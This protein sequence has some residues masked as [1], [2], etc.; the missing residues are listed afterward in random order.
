MCGPT[1]GRAESRL[2]PI[3]HK[4]F[5]AP[6][7]DLRTRSNR[8]VFPVGLISACS[9]ARLISAELPLVSDQEDCSAGLAGLRLRPDER[10]G[11]GVICAPTKDRYDELISDL[12]Q[13]GDVICLMLV[14]QAK[15]FYARRPSGVA[16]SP[17]RLRGDVLGR[18]AHQLIHD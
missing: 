3:R 7:A 14:E 1:R 13:L 9:L 5:I 2:D 16:A 8:M 17:G 10:W 6:N 11:R 4:T 18:E 15:I 12:V